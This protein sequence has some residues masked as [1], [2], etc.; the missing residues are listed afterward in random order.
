V[1]KTGVT[2]NMQLRNTGFAL[3][4]HPIVPVKTQGRKSGLAIA[5]WG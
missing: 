4:L 2:Q 5:R 1:P 3:T